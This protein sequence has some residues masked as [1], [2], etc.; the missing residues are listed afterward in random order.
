MVRFGITARRV[1][2]KPRWPPRPARETQ[3][4]FVARRTLTVR[5]PDVQR[6]HSIL[7]IDA[8]LIARLTRERGWR[9]GTMCELELGVCR[10]QVTIPVRDSHRRL[11]GLLRYQP[12]PQAG[13]PKMRAAA[14]SCRMLLPHPTAEPSHDVL[15]VEG[16]PDMVAAR[17][18]G[19]PA[20][21]LPGLDCWRSHWAQLLAGRQIQIITDAD[22][23][24]RAVATRIAH[25]LNEYAS[26]TIVDLAPNRDDGYD[27]TDWLLEQT[28]PGAEPR[29]RRVAA[30]LDRI[31][32][33]VA[34]RDP[35]E[36]R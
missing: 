33:C 11:I 32:G 5:E 16:E 19:L 24:G 36:V 26:T 7:R 30:L 18:R 34:S 6:W 14:G 28:P 10:G 1:E 29:R 2:T 15:L 8:T 9:K 21:A 22:A 25:D 31:S 35:R 4:P 13:R 23:H 17:S 12:W 3:P 27:L 20:I